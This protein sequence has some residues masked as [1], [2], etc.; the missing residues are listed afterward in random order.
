MRHPLAT[1]FTTD[2]LSAKPGSFLYGTTSASTF[3]P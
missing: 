2:V 3:S 1:G